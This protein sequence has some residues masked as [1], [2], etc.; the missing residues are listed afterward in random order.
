MKKFLISLLALALVGSVV[1]FAETDPRADK[2]IEN[3]KDGKTGKADGKD[4]I[5]RNPRIS[6]TLRVNQIQEYTAANG[7]ALE[8]VTLKDGSVN[9]TNVTAA[10][11]IDAVAVTSEVAVVEGDLTVSIPTDGGNAGAQNTIQ[12]LMK[13]KMVALG[14]MT[15][16]STETVSLMDDTPAADW[17]AI[18]GTAD[19][20]DTEDAT[21]Y[22]VGSKSLKLVW[23]DAAVDGDGVSDTIASDDWEA[24]ESIGFWFMATGTVASGDFEFVLTDDGG[25]RTFNIPAYTT[26]NV[27]KWI[28]IDISSLNAGTGDAITAIKILISAQ[29]AAAVSDI[30]MY[31]DAIWCWDVDEEEALGVNL[32]QDGV[33]SV[34]TVATAAGSANTMSLEVENTDYFIHYESGND[35]IVTSAD[36]SANS[37][38][39]LVVYQ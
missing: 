14:T 31:I 22:R 21:Y 9:T 15:D 3:I 10:G 25:D 8:N 6:G 11:W 26:P 37:G 7:M 36:H 13:V 20:T 18:G 32:V 2:W 30:D 1:S 34:M 5:L 23:L 12:G 33:M 29:G 17:S 19:P 35:F 24:N 28:E 16:G 39:A 38:I 27:W 4:G